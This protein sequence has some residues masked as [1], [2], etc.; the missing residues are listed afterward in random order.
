MDSTRR[1]ILR[2]LHTEPT[3]GPALAEE[4]HITRAAVWKHID[5]LREEGVKIGTQSEG[6]VVESLPE[7][8]EAAIAAHLSDDYDIVYREVVE[9]TND[10]ARG[11][12][13]DT[14]NPTIIAAHQQTS[15]RGRLNRDWMGP[16]GGIYCSLLSYPRLSPM[17]APLVTMVAAVA[18]ARALESQHMSPTIKW[19]N[20]VQ[21]DGEK[22]AGILT[23]MQGEADR[24][25]WVIVGIGINANVE[26]DTLPSGATSIRS[27]LGHDCHRAEMIQSIVASFEE[28]IESP[29]AALDA[30]RVRTDTLGRRVRIET[31]AETIIGEAIDIELPGSLIVETDTGRQ[32]VLA[33]DCEHLRPATKN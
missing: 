25:S 16:P 6:Y 12:V 20:D 28:L 11:H 7:Y 4:L 19:P 24:I 31:A 5:Q 15:G 30:W 18:V 23:E 33:G 21:V 3:T 17:D 10:I 27:V 2:R 1:A 14:E 22:V 8:G 29:T 13:S 9:S 32:R 26:Q